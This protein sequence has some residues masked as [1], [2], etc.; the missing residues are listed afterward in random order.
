MWLYHS[1]IIWSAEN[2]HICYHSQEELFSIN[3]KENGCLNRQSVISPPVLFSICMGQQPLQLCCAWAVLHAQC[4]CH[5]WARGYLGV[6]PNLADLELDHI[7]AMDSR[8]IHIC[9]FLSNVCC[10]SEIA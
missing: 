2:T 5:S 8:C 4:C 6:R 3:L 10:N 7:W 1:N 9:R